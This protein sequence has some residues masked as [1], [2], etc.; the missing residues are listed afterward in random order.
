MRRTLVS[1]S[2]SRSGIRPSL[3]AG[4]LLAALGATPAEPASPAG[5]AIS[6]TAASAI[7]PGAFARRRY[8]TP[9]AGVC[10]NPI[11][12]QKDWL[13]QSEHGA[14]YQLIGGA[15]RMSRGR[16]EGPLGST[17][18]ELV[19]LEGGRGI[20][21]GDAETAYSA[22]YMGNSKAGLVPHLAFHDLDNAFIFS[23][24]FPAVGVVA[25]LD[26][27]PSV[28]LWDRA[29]YPKGFHSVADLRAFASSGKGKIY[30]STTKRTFGRY[31][32]SRGIPQSAFMEGFR[33]DG[34]T[35]VINNGAWLNQGTV[36]NEVY[37]FEHGFNWRKPID[38]VFV[39]DLGYDVYPSMVAVATSRLE[40]L[41][42]CLT[43]LVPLLQQAQVD[44]VSDPREVNDL[45]V[46]FA[47][48]KMAAPFWRMPADLVDN[49]VLVQRATGLVGNGNNQT[50]GDFD[51]RRVAGLLAQIRGALDVRAKKGVTPEDV[52]TNRFID[53]RIGLPAT[54]GAPPR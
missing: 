12:V 1:G 49:A 17:G 37:Q 24:R 52:V 8:R 33:G 31:L 36:T 2:S 54:T 29:T 26:K 14:L 4:L 7:E 6:A 11:V 27:S 13:I 3:V 34:E 16:Y 30:V 42:P 35:F 40:E 39:S 51:L 44:Y 48:A 22:L 23:A 47:A 15:G 28:L 38:Y 18:I 5:S 25:L 46:R 43:R 10:P 50:L 20:G 45:I 19:V 9:L 41:A 53:P 32:L 21:L